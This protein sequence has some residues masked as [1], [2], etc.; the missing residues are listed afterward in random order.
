MSNP[1]DIPS[2]I[3]RPADWQTRYLQ[4]REAQIREVPWYPI[5]QGQPGGI[6]SPRLK[7]F[8]VDESEFGVNVQPQEWDTWPWANVTAT[9]I[10]GW[11]AKPG[12]DT[13]IVINTGNN[14]LTI[15]P[16]RDK[17]DLGNGISLP[18][19]DTFTISTQAAGWISAPSGSTSV[20]IAITFNQAP[21]S[22]LPPKPA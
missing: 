19:G 5:K 6:I 20:Q 16:T 3:P 10:E 14:P 11:P 9:P 21:T 8:S 15:S 13:V 2:E 1:S 4:Q 7:A 17:A 18:A 12:Q 22:H